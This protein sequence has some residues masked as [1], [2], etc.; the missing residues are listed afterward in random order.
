MSAGAIRADCCAVAP[1]EVN[2][3]TTAPATIARTLRVLMFTPAGALRPSHRFGAASATL[4]C[5]RGIYPEHQGLRSPRIFPAMR[6][7][8]LEIQAVAGLQP[9]V[10]GFAQPDLE[11]TAQNVQKFLALVGVRFAAPPAGLYSEEMRLHRRVAPCQ[12]FHPY[13]RRSFQHLALR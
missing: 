3:P 1:L 10:L 9:V 11:F 8:T 6:R 13:A 4:E 7:G 5:G 2:R 12:K